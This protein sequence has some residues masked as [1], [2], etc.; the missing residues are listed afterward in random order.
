MGL[1]VMLVDGRQST[2]SLSA[3]RVRDYIHV[4]DIADAHVR[5]LEYL[6]EKE[7]AAR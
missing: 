6:M 2:G 4:S 1:A 7:E 3:N 5:A